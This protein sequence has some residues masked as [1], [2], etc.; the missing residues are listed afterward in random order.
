MAVGL[1]R[2]IFLVL[3]RAKAAAED[4]S[5]TGTCAAG[6]DLNA[7]LDRLDATGD[8]MRSSR[9]TLQA[10]ESVRTNV[11]SGQRVILPAGAR[12]HLA[13]GSPLVTEVSYSAKHRPVNTNTSQHIHWVRTIADDT[14][15]RHM[16]LLPLK[17]SAS[18]SKG[19]TS[20]VVTVD[21]S[22]RLSLH[23]M[24]GDPLLEAFDLGHQKDAKVKFL[25]LSPNQEHHFVLTADSFGEMRV[26]SLKIVARRE[27]KERDEDDDDFQVTPE[28][29]A[30]KRQMVVS[31]NFSCAFALPEA[32][33]G[34]MRK[35]TAI[36]PVD[37]NSQ[38]YFVVGDADGGIAVF[39]RN[40]TFRGRVI[41]TDDPGGI[42]G[43]A[44][45]QSQSVLFYSS[46]RFGF[47]STYQIDV[48]FV[49]C[50]GWHVPLYD[51]A[52]DPNSASARVI[53]SLV[54]GD[55]IVFNTMNGK[56]RACDLFVK[57]PRVS[58]V[59]FR[60]DA[61]RGH[62]LG[63]MAPVDGV[64]P[65]EDFA[66]EVFFFNLN[67]MEE[68][69]GLA[70]SRT[71]V[72]QANFK[73]KQPVDLILQSG[74]G[75]G[76]RSRGQLVVRMR[77][78]KGVELYDITLKQP[79][80]PVVSSVSS[81]DSGWFSWFPRF[82]VFGV[83]LFG[84]FVWNIWKYSGWGEGGMGDIDDAELEARIK[85]MAAKEGIDLGAATGGG[86]GFASSSGDASY[87]GGG[88]GSF[89]YED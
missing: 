2:F 29:R 47:F 71:V 38:T 37:R 76:E 81:N 27:R 14:D 67:S 83:V 66:P 52:V 28:V 22:S 5:S 10:L 65:S 78:E 35:L 32:E 62:I 4:C 40:G 25:A 41:A 74:S 61:F 49:P 60:L 20:L 63:L 19:S 30:M 39:H 33:E 86:G 46:H 51:L 85:E 75:S 50:T 68:G 72:L 15:V 26:H 21:D 11:L 54:D 45:G 88:L 7:I 64:F 57:F 80:A 1:L 6:P 42:V 31:A 34:P 12:Q 44:R 8:S 3:C 56:S 17:K 70:P 43:L 82:G 48:Q 59:P 87:S 24:E 89:D 77:G 84:V 55:I 36:L 69:Y 58:N 79:A 16:A 73:P 18:H 9:L 53:L 13:K 23:S